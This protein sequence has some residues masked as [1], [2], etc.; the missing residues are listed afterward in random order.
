MAC[1]GNLV[2]IEGDP[3][4]PSREVRIGETIDI[5]ADGP[6][7]KVRVLDLPKQRIGARLADEFRENLTPGDTGF[8]KF[9]FLDHP[10]L[11][12]PRGMGRPTKRERRLLEGFFEQNSTRS[13]TVR[14][15]NPDSR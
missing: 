6:V 12:R 15:T 9:D 14:D 1:R 2:K 4:K 8:G 10:S 11:R 3:V 7:R 13:G 5:E